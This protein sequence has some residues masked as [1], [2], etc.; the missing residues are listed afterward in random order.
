MNK[1]AVV[2]VEQFAEWFVPLMGLELAPSKGFR[3]TFEI[4]TILGE[5]IG[6]LEFCSLRRDDNKVSLDL[7][8]WGTIFDKYL[9]YKEV[10]GYVMSIENGEKKHF[11]MQIVIEIGGNDR[12]Y[13]GIYILEEK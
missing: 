12:R 4:K 13:D 11:G 3:A 1:K 2:I 5:E 10:A 9:S 7:E 8:S 6:E